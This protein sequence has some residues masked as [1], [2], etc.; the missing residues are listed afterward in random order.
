[1]RLRA[2]VQPARLGQGVASRQAAPRIGITE[3]RSAPQEQSRLAVG[4]EQSELGLDGDEACG[5]RQNA[6]PTNVRLLFTYSCFR[7]TG[8][9]QLITGAMCTVLFLAAVFAPLPPD[10]SLHI[11]HNSAGETSYSC[12]GSCPGGVPCQTILVGFALQCHC[13]GVENTAVCSGEHLSQQAFPGVYC[14]KNFVCSPATQKCVKQDD[15]S[16]GFPEP[17]IPPRFMLACDCE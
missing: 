10:C 5:I 4:N 7:R 13:N 11:Y 6:L 9:M 2:A 12:E 8:V 17:G 16:L 1:V 14:N 15:S 3:L